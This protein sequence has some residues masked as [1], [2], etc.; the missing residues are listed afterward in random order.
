MVSARF[1]GT[2]TATADAFSSWPL[3]LEVEIEAVDPALRGYLAPLGIPVD[4]Q[5]RASLQVTGSLS[6]PFL[7]GRDP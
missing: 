2:A 1:A 4:P 5:G 6:A 7:S 3:D